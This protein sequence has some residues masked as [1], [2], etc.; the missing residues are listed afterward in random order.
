MGEDEIPCSVDIALRGH[1]S[2]ILGEAITGRPEQQLETKQ[3]RLPYDA[4]LD[5]ICQVLRKV[6]LRALDM[7]VSLDPCTPVSAG[8]SHRVCAGPTGPV[9]EIVCKRR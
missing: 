6:R 3:C 4:L 9:E 5:H 2:V 7:G 1:R 8:R